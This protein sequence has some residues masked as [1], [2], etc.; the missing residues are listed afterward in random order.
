MASTEITS[1]AINFKILELR[2]AVQ[3]TMTQPIC[4][5]SFGYFPLS[6]SSCKHYSPGILTL[7]IL[8][9]FPQRMAVWGFWPQ[10]WCNFCCRWKHQ[11]VINWKGW[12]NNKRQTPGASKCGPIIINQTMSEQGAIGIN[13]IHAPLWC[14]KCATFYLE[15]IISKQI[16]WSR[17]Q[18]S[19]GWSLS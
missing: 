5:Y 18:L 15:M 13:G 3:A 4:I 12:K 6:F 16:E 1:V 10:L 14:G 9:H 2:H 19:N 7:N 17:S 8:M 11:L